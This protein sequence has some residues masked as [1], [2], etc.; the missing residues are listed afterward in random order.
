MAELN[1][2]YINPLDWRKYKIC[3]EF[4]LL[5][6]LAKNMLCMTAKSLHVQSVFC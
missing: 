5:S 1:G 6:L 4:L 2:D 3:T